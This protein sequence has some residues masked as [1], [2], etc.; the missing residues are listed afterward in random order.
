[1]QEINEKRYA[2]VK[3]S[4]SRLYPGCKVEL[5]RYLKS[6]DRYIVRNIESD[7]TCDV[8]AGDLEVI[9]NKLKEISN[10]N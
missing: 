2:I 6:V 1:M 4:C 8:N 7:Y 10:E 3:E 5:L 9:D